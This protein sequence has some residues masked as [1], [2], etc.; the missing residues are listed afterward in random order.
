[1]QKLLDDNTYARIRQHFERLCVADHQIYPEFT[2]THFPARG[3]LNTFILL[4]LEY[5]QPILPILHIPTL[6]LSE[7][8]WL[9]GLA[10]AVLG[11]RF[12]DLEDMESFTLSMLEFLR[13]AV[14]YVIE[15]SDGS[16]PSMEIAQAQLLLCVGLAYSGDEALLNKARNIHR[17][18]VRFCF[19]AWRRARRD[20]IK[21]DRVDVDSTVHA[22]HEWKDGETRRRTGYAIWMLDCMLAYHHQWRPQLTLE[23]ACLPLPCPEILWESTTALQWRQVLEYSA[24]SPSLVVAIETIYIEKKLQS[25]M[26]EFSRI[27]IIHGLFHRLWEVR[28]YLEQ[29]LTYWIPSAKRQSAEALIPKSIWLPEIPAYAKWRNSTCDSLD[30]LHWSANSVIGAASG[31]EHPTVAHLHLSRIILLTPINDIRNFATGL[32]N[33]QNRRQSIELEGLRRTVRRWATEDEHKARLAMIH[34]GVVFWHVRRYSAN[35]FYEPHAV[36]LASLALWAYATFCGSSASDPHTRGE[37]TVTALPQSPEYAEDETSL[38]T[39]INLDRPADDELVQT[40]IRRGRKMLAMMSGVGD[41]C[42]AEG[43]SRVL[44]EGVK[45]LGTLGNW[46]C[47]R[48][49]ME[50]LR[51]LRAVERE[52]VLGVG[53]RTGL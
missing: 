5:F 48:W 29:P 6:D 14:A 17:D 19:D 39:S 30:I 21:P 43:P 26:G 3:H 11:C 35:A 38:P 47:S 40:F 41:V 20:F 37:G 51:R 44:G 18:M 23:D 52:T 49:G 53:G 12:L 16:D 9:L 42:G 22:W 15:K 36:F 46:E 2:S 1:M 24:P 32:M 45:L 31:M 34:A 4:Y 10:M 50:M 27:L 7:S 25:T 28:T 33:Q 8:H 13:R